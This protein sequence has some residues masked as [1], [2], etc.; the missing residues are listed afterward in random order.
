[1]HHAFEFQMPVLIV[2]CCKIILSLTIQSHKQGNNSNPTTSLDRNETTLLINLLM[3]FLL[4]QLMYYTNI[5]CSTKNNKIVRNSN[6][7]MTI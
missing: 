4:N 6:H 1:M 2:S 5:F 7:K 3:I